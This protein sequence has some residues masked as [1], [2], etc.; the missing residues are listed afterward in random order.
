MATH[1][2]ELAPTPRRLAE[3]AALCELLVLLGHAGDAAMLQASL[4]ALVAAQAEA[5]GYVRAHPAPAAQQTGGSA[6]GPAAAAG[7]KAGGQADAVAWKWDVL[8]AVKPDMESR[9]GSS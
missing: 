1:L 7:G 8:R 9:L 5:A 3:A 2:L 6:G 4:S